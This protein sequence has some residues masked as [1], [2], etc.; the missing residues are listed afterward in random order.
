M[1]RTLIILPDAEKDAANPYNWYEQQEPGLGEEFL[2]CIDA[3]IQLI[4]RNP[5]IYQVV[6]ETYRKAIV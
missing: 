6:H 1:F 4:R 2:R 5:E 3:R